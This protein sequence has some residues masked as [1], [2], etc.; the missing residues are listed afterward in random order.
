M[1]EQ[2]YISEEIEIGSG[3]ITIG[4]ASN[5]IKGFSDG[6]GGVNFANDATLNLNLGV[7]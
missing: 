5:A 1:D 4:D 6:V 2:D 7:S 3:T